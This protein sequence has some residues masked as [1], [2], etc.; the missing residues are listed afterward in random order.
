MDEATAALD[1]QTEAEV[2]KALTDVERGRTIITI[3][4]R[5]TTIKN[6]DIIYMIDN[7]KVVSAGSYAELEKRCALFRE[8][9]R[10]GGA[11]S[12]IFH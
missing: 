1:N 3:A 7:G 9:V 12:E 8:M 10:L 4:H 6:H 5:L 2:T 11:L